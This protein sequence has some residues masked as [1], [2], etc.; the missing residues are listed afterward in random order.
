M[1]IYDGEDPGPARQAGKAEK[2]DLE[3]PNCGWGP[4]DPSPNNPWN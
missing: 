2:I 4:T 3:S 1:E